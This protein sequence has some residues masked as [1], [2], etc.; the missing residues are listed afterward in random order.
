M[1]PTVLRTEGDLQ[2]DHLYLSMF[3]TTL[4]LVDTTDKTYSLDDLV[5]QEMMATK[6]CIGLTGAAGFS[7]VDLVRNEM[8]Y[9]S[10]RCKQG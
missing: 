2:V 9:W 8:M 6:R 1:S 3:L 5:R 10:D 4:L 7:L